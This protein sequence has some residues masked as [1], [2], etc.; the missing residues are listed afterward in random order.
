MVDPDYCHIRGSDRAQNS[1]IILIPLISTPL[2]TLPRPRKVMANKD[3]NQSAAEAGQSGLHLV[4]QSAIVLNSTAAFSRE[5]RPNN[6]ISP[7]GHHTGSEV[8]M[9][10]RVDWKKAPKNAIWWAVDA[11]GTA[12]WFISPDIKPFTGFWFTSQMPAPL[13]AFFGDWRESLTERP[14][15]AK[16]KLIDPMS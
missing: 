6:S 15:V 8:Y 7:F 13:F 1:L 16:L 11:D 14:P 4:L 12:H 2:F 9:H 10:Q 3:S 5:R